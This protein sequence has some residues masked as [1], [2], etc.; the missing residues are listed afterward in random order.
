MKRKAVRQTKRRP[1]RSRSDR[2]AEEVAPSRLKRQPEPTVT[3][4]MRMRASLRTKLEKLAARNRRSV[5]DLAQQL[6]DE[7]I[8]VEECPGIYFAT[9]PSGRT[10][11]VQGT[12]LGVWEVLRQYVHDRNE[13][14]LRESFHWLSN[15]QIAAALG[16]YARYRQEIDAEVAENEYW[17]PERLAEDLPGLVRVV[18]VDV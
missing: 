17:T 18:E 1:A 3:T 8:R 6:I 14:T 11:K 7:G 2:V 9:E 10:A 4:T 13:T 15:T 5:S 16:Y 12:G